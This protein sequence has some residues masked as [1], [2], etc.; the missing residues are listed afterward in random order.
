MR[1]PITKS[2][3]KRAYETYIN[4]PRGSKGKVIK[5]LAQKLGL[6]ESQLRR[7]FRKI[8]GGR[9]RKRSPNRYRKDDIL[10]AIHYARVK[11]VSLLNACA[12]MIATKKV[13][14]LSYEEV[15]DPVR[16]FY[17]A[18]MRFIKSS[19][20]YAPK[21]KRPSRRMLKLALLKTSFDNTQKLLLTL[22]IDGLLTT[23]TPL[24][25]DLLASLEKLLRENLLSLRRGRYFITPKL[26]YEIL[27]SN[28][29]EGT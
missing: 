19:N 18:V 17:L 4:T 24:S 9:R 10:Y 15:K 26:R 6:S 5:E 25:G 7:A 1:R 22:A 13:V 23:H 8:Y 11:R 16:A 21:S 20:S 12:Y 27:E 14:R 29:F 28:L 3:L 2:K